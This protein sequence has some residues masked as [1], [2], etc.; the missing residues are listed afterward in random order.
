MFNLLGNG[1]KMFGQVGPGL[2]RLSMSGGIAVKTSNGYRS[3]DIKTNR[4]T[5]CDNF[6]LDV[7]DDFFFVLPTNRVVPGDIIIAGNK[8]KCVIESKK[9]T[10]K[11]VNYED[12]TV[13]TILPERHIFMGNT[14]FFGKIVS[15]FAA[16]A[17]KGKN[18]MNKIMKYMMLSSMM[19][20]NGAGGNSNMA[21]GISAMLPLMMMGGGMDLFD[22]MFDDMD[23]ED[24]DMESDA[25]EEKEE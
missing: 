13:E 3:Y 14:Y 10:I 6:A 16:N 22:G 8:P 4:L 2:C 5:N 21:G 7:G 19:K 18:G 17:G 11:A 1:S 12:M 23:D 24:E 25:E 9:G 15:P 20:N